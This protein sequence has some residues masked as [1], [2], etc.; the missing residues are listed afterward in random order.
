[1][2]PPAIHIVSLGCSK[3][4]VDSERLLAASVHSLG[5]EPTDQAEEA[6]LILVS[7]CAFLQSAVEEALTNIIELGLVK[8]PGAKMV[9]TGCLPARYQNQDLNRGLTE[10]DL[11]LSPADYPYF[12]SWVGKLC[13]LKVQRTETAFDRHTGPRGERILG[14][15]FFRAFLKIAE[16][17]NNHCSYC[18]IPSLRGP[19]T[20]QDQQQLLNE[21]ESLVAGGVRELTLVAQDLTAYGQDQGRSGALVE[22][23]KLLDSI[24]GLDWLRL[25]YVYPDS[26]TEELVKDLAAIPKVVP[27]LD[28][29][30]Q[31]VNTTVL[32]NMGRCGSNPLELVQKL[33]GWW[34]EVTLRTTLMVGFPGESEERFSELLEFVNE[35]A[36]DHLGAFKFS[37]E[38]E[39]QATTFPDQVPQGLK[40]KRRRKIMA[41]QRKVS[42]ARNRQRLGQVV[43]V[44][45]EGSTL[46]TPWV[47]T[48]RAYFQAPEVDGLIFFDGEQPQQGQIVKTLLLKATAYDLI[49][50]L[51]ED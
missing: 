11:W 21:A 49:G 16:G 8:K 40:E 25:L 42:L 10:V 43:E 5:F 48:G 36:F 39:I 17:C 15:P 13:G 3:N 4:L 35:A 1:M 2:S 37:P 14:T 45:V 27:Y 20:S 7:T 32:K 9:A 23:V 19:L 47:Q 22:L 29:P 33:R 46:D 26:L 28:V 18:L 30:F 38:A 44:L 12:E 31:H 6:D 51:Q 24:P 50:Q 34:P 41:A